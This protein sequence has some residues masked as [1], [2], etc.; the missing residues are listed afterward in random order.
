MTAIMLMIDWRFDMVV[1]AVALVL[2]F[3]VQ[4]YTTRLR[5]AF[6]RA[7]RKEGEL[8]S[9]AQEIISNV[10]VVQAYGRE[11]HED[12]RF[13]EQAE[14]SLG[15]TLEA[16]ELQLQFTPLVGLV[17]AMATGAVIWYGAS[18]VLAGRITAGELLVFLAYLRGMALPVR[19]VAKVA[20]VVGE[21]SVAAERLWDVVS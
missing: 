2:L 1:I 3:I 14:Q 7:R 10:H 12:D 16:S 13:A 15:A 4:S 8:W 9:K 5:L 6:R 17:M 18:Q 21:S 20:R 19:E 11:P